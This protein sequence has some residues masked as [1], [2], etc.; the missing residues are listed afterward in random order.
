MRG[1]S[2]YSIPCYHRQACN[3]WFVQSASPSREAT[4]RISAK[5]FTGPIVLT[6]TPRGVREISTAVPQ[7]FLGNGTPFLTPLTRERSLLL[8]DGSAH[9]PDRA[10]LM[11]RS[12]LNLNPQC[13][14][15]ERFLGRSYTPLE[16]LPLRGRRGA[17]RSSKDQLRKT[18]TEG[19]LDLYLTVVEELA[20]EGFEMADIA[21]AAARLAR[22]LTAILPDLTL[23]APSTPPASSAP[24]ASPAGARRS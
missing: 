10:M 19:D 15:P 18:H 23:A 16:Y 11:P 3:E 13:F 1:P 21:A 22:R 24:L 4:G 8:S 9:K 20:A 14:R 2:R 6:R 7:I 17:S 12:M 5:L